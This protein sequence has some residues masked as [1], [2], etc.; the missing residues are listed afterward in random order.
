MAAGGSKTEK[1]EELEL[2]VTKEENE[3]K[4]DAESGFPFWNP[5]ITDL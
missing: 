4:R 1:T 2:I 5:I 3:K